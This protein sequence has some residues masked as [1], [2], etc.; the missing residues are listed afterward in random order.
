MD[1]R[2][3]KAFKTRIER[4][5]S[6]KYNRTFKSLLKVIKGYALLKGGIAL[7]L[8]IL[9]HSDFIVSVITDLLETLYSNLYYSKEHTTHE[10]YD[11]KI[12]W[13]NYKKTFILHIKNRPKGSNEHRTSFLC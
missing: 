8:T 1:K 11:Y 10:L 12:I 5:K 4:R 13:N 2:S 9:K 6:E 7:S 3:K